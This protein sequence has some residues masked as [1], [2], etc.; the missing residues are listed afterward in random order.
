MSGPKQW[1]F[2]LD[3]CLEMVPFQFI[4]DSLWTDRLLNDGIDI[5]C[6]LDSIVYFASG[7]LID[8]PPL[9]S[10]RESMDGLPPLWFSLS[11]SN[12]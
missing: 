4:P 6:G 8:N 11:T 12:S 3:Y 2:C 10:V 1:L 9:V 7:N 5:V